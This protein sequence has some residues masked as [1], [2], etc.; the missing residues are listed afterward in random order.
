[1]TRQTL[2]PVVLAVVLVGLA[3][4]KTRYE[5]SVRN[6]ADQPISAQIRTGNPKG[7][8][9]SLDAARV[10]PGDRDTLLAEG[11]SSFKKVF[12]SVDFEGN[13]GVAQTAKLKRGIT[14]VIVRRADEGSQGTIDLELVRP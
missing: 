10:G 9:A 4:C 12:I 13:T 6:N 14:A 5:V 7:N 8:S 1:M 3:G 2:L 11:V